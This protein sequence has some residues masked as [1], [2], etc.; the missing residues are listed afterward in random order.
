MGLRSAIRDSTSD[1]STASREAATRPARSTDTSQGGTS[2]APL[3]VDRAEEQFG[4]E[5][6]DRRTLQRL[7]MHEE[8][9]GE[10][11]HE[12]VDEGMPTDIMGK[13]RDMEAFRERQAER[14]P[15][16]PTDIERR[17][18]RSV[19]RSEQAAETG[20]AGDAGVPEPVREVISSTGRSLDA[21]IQRAME[22]RMGDSL[23]DVRIHTGPQAAAACE[24]INARAFTVGNHVAFNQGEYDPSSPEGQHVLAHELAHVRQQAQGAVSMLPQEDLELEIDPDSALEREAE[25]T[26]QRVMQGGELGIQRLRKTEVHIQR[27]VGS[28][29]SGY[30]SGG[31]SK[32]Q[33]NAGTGLFGRV[34]DWMRGDEYDPDEEGVESLDSASLSETLQTVVD[35]VADLKQTV[36]GDDGI[37]TKKVA[38]KGIAPA[39]VAGGAGVVASASLPA[40]LLGAGGAFLAGGAKELYGQ[41]IERSLKEGSPF[42]QEFEELK[43]KFNALAETV[44][45]G[46]LVG[47]ETGERT[48]EVDY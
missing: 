21:S 33:D 40:T 16:V 17:N 46:N 35:D 1:G 14:P 39:L 8:T 7:R 9:Y 28:P 11:V 20:A 38:A 29:Q 45:L 4:M 37:D 30:L 32:D 5:I 44:G 12:W 13:T 47:S 26:A 36:Y 34:T 31:G 22:D 10:R 23:G 25:E 2:A 3:G 42:E 6:T 41:S 43:S 27:A 19:Q 24:S 48:N 15:E 18:K